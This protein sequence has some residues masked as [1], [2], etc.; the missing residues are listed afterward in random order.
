MKTVPDTIETTCGPLND[1]WRR[2]ALELI[3][4]HSIDIAD[5]EDALNWDA[6]IGRSVDFEALS[7]VSGRP[8]SA[9]DFAP[10]RERGIS[11]EDLADLW[12][13]KPLRDHL[14]HNH[15]DPQTPASASCKL[16]LQRAG[17]A[18]QHLCDAFREIPDSSSHWSVRALL[19]NSAGLAD[20]GF[21]FRRWLERESMAL[22]EA[23]FPPRD[24]R[25]TVV[26]TD[27]N[28]LAQRSLEHALVA[29]MGR[30]FHRTGPDIAAHI[31]SDW[32]LGLWLEGET[33]VFDLYPHN[34]HHRAFAHHCLVIPH[35]AVEFVAWWHAQP[36][37]R[38]L[39][40]R[41]ASACMAS[42]ESTAAATA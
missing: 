6:F 3:R 8:T 23:E 10:L 1:A 27:H 16:L 34:I 33:G 5:S 2:F 14:L 29:I 30:T 35:D 37:C 13:L 20:C 31:L 40:P 26:M 22:G 18:G 11:L 25:R 19:Q 17:P 4:T 28:G 42:A 36:G 32:Q 24:F 21:S 15:E 9:P 41:I 7:G 12:S 38:D 39:P